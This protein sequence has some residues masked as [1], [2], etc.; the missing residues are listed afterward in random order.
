MY[1]NVC[2]ILCFRGHSVE[3]YNKF[4]GRLCA[5]LM[6]KIRDSFKQTLGN[7]DGPETKI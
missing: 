4:Y 1:F 5:N 2:F 6:V 3:W 7:T